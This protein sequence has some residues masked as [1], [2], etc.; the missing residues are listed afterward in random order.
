MMDSTKVHIIVALHS[1]TTDNEDRRYPV[2]HHMLS[3]TQ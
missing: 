1:D 2:D 3:A